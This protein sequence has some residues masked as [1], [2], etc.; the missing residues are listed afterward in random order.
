VHRISVW[1]GESACASGRPPVGRIAR[2]LVQIHRGAL[3]IVMAT[4]PLSSPHEWSAVASPGGGF[5]FIDCQG[6]PPAPFTV[7]LPVRLGK[8]RLYDGGVLPATERET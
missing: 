3:V 8:R 7:K 5:D 1:V 4:V 6:A 2:P